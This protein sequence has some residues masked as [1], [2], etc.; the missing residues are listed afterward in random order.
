MLKT[1]PHSSRIF[2]KDS[3]GAIEISDGNA[4]KA[5]YL[6]NVKNWI[7][8]IVGGGITKSYLGAIGVDCML[9]EGRLNPSVCFHIVVAGGGPLK[10]VS[11]LIEEKYFVPFYKHDYP[12]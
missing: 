3:G 11:D 2:F 5:Y 12:C 1:E 7:M 6:D 10:L 4:I 8:I 9:E